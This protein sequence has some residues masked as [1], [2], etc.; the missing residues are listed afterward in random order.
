M[1]LMTEE[2]FDRYVEQHDKAEARFMREHNGCL[3]R[4]EDGQKEL[5]EL[6]EVQHAETKALLQQE[7]ADRETCA[8][9]CEER[10]S[11]L[12]QPVLEDKAR[13]K[14]YAGWKDKLLV[15]LSVSV[16]VLTIATL[17][18]AFTR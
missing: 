6:I 10:L 17:V 18:L 11:A 1:G 2:N 5:K 9:N 16:S 15:V 4:L 13:R 7:Q 3:Q 14:L 8:E 12:E